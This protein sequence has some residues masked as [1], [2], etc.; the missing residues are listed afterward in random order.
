[1]VWS[2]FWWEWNLLTPTFIDSKSTIIVI[3]QKKLSHETKAKSIRFW[4]KILG[5]QEDY[6]IAEVDL[7]A[8]APENV[9]PDP[10]GVFF[11]PRGSPGVNQYNY[12]V[13]NSGTNALY[14]FEKNSYWRMEASSRFDS[15]AINQGQKGQAYLHRKFGCRYYY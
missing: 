5:S 1:M 9:E 7:E 15:W 6:Y 12:Y 10:E 8:N 2:S 4:G 11:E 13:S 14:I 3:D